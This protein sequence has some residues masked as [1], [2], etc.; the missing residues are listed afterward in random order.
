MRWRSLALW[1][2]AASLV[3]G[4][5]AAAQGNPSPAQAPPEGAAT[6]PASAPDAAAQLNISPEQ[7]ARALADILSDPRKRFAYG[8][9]GYERVRTYL[10]RD[11]MVEEIEAVYRKLLVA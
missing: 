2:L 9:A 8:E 6:P 1:C 4:P 11:R 5:T 3:A 7:I 10:N